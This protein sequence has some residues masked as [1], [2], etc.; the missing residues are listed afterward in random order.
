M[1]GHANGLFATFVF[2]I[3]LLVLPTNYASEY[4][5]LVDYLLL[6]INEITTKTQLRGRRRPAT[7]TNNVKSISLAPKLCKKIKIGI[8]AIYL[9]LISNLCHN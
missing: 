6:F 1:C 4:A 7:C 5:M 3:M 9:Y 8:F 2:S